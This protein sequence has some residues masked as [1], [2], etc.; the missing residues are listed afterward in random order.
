M[1]LVTINNTAFEVGTSPFFPGGEAVFFNPSPVTEDDDG[2]LIVQG[3][4]SGT[5]DWEELA[6]VPA[7]DM[8]Q[9]D[10]L[11][12]FIRVSTSASVRMLG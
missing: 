8:V 11:P 6:T 5:G 12:A 7:G 4:A 10:E 2:E 1:K 3:S 9:V